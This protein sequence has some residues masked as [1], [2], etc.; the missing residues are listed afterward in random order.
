MYKE[1]LQLDRTDMIIL[2]FPRLDTGTVENRI[3]RLTRQSTIVS[4]AL[5]QTGLRFSLVKYEKPLLRAA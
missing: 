3:K 2:G 1:P 5:A 4:D